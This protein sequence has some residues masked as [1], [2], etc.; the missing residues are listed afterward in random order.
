[1]AIKFFRRYFATGSIG[2]IHRGGADY[3]TKTYGYDSFGNKNSVTATG[4]GMSS[5]ISTITYDSL[6]RFPITSVDSLGNAEH[7][8][9]SA[10][11]G[12]LH[13]FQ[14]ANLLTTTWG[15]DALGRK[16]SE[17][18]PDGTS[19]NVTYS[20]LCTTSCGQQTY[21]VQIATSGEPTVTTYYDLLDREYQ[22]SMGGFNSSTIWS[23]KSYDGVGR[24]LATSRN[25]YS[26]GAPSYTYF[27]Y[28]NG[29][30]IVQKYDPDGGFQKWSY[31]NLTTTISND[32]NQ[33]RIETKDSLG[34]LSQA[35]DAAGQV[36]QYKY[37]PFGNLTTTTDPQG[38]Q[39][40]ATY[41]VMGRKTRVKDPD[42]G[43][44]T[45]TY[46]GAGDQL[47]QTDAKNQTQTMTYDLFG[48]L[49]TKQ[50]IEF[51]GTWTYDTATNGLE[52][53]ASVTNSAGFTK[54]FTYD[55]YGRVANEQTTTDT[56]YTIG[57]SYDSNSRLSQITY[58]T[59]FAVSYQYDSNGYLKELDNAS[60]SAM[61]WQRNAQNADN[62]SLQDTFGNGVVS[63]STYYTTTGRLQSL[64]ATSGSTT[65]QN[66]NVSYDTL[67]NVTQRTDLTNQ[68]TGANLTDSY[69]YDNLNRL[70][71]D[72]NARETANFSYDPLGDM[73]SKTNVG[74]MKYGDGRSGRPLHAVMSTNGPTQNTYSYDA[75][76]NMISGA[77]R[78]VTWTSFNKPATLANASNTI[79]FSYDPSFGRYKE[80]ETTCQDYLGNSSTTCTKYLVNPREDIGIH[81]EK[82]INGS[83]TSY[84][85]SLYAG[86]GN[87]VGVYTTRSDGTSSTNYYHKDHLGSVVLSTTDNAGVVERSSYD[88]FGKRRNVIGTD[89]PSDLLRSKVSHQ[90][91]TGHEMMDDGG[92]GLINMNGRVYEP[93]LGRFMS[94]DPHVQQPGNLQ[95]LN[96]Y[97]YTANNPVSLT[98][99][100]GYLFG[101]NINLG[102]VVG[103]VAGAVTG[104]DI[105]ALAGGIFGSSNPYVQSHAGQIA[106]GEAV[107]AASVLTFGGVDAALGGGL[108]AAVIAGATSG[109]VAGGLSSTLSSGGFSWQDVEMGAVTG[110]IS[111]GAGSL[112]SGA[113]PA[114]QIAVGG[115][116]GGTT[117]WLQSA[118]QGH[119]GIHSFIDG[120]IL[121]TVI[122]ATEVGLGYLGS[123]SEQSA[124]SN[125][126]RSPAMVESAS[127]GGGAGPDDYEGGSGGV[128]LNGG[129]SE[130][131]D[132]DV[133]GNGSFNYSDHAVTRM[134]QND[135]THEDVVD[136]IMN[137]A[138]VPGQNATGFTTTFDGNGL[139][140]VVGADGNTIVTVFPNGQ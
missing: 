8:T 20:T 31:S 137:N 28:D 33:Q 75:N 90:G 1:V 95:S 135:I 99:P 42:L 56:S 89:D 29:N 45:Y 53:L 130:F 6:G 76:G 120:A 123:S 58:P 139:R 48:R 85:H 128:G 16:T 74:D 94:A 37:D 80:V 93:L 23:Y 27:T 18:R 109:A 64:V 77:G 57:R 65:L 61:L 105:G 43:T 36:T 63:A 113:G 34:Q 125:A 59:G 70:T 112:A 2:T 132:A 30:R 87:V 129:G 55:S 115:L 44:W 69:N 134:N 46:D 96:R 47:T 62:L 119:A 103:A 100:S 22:R 10:A 108:G 81:F 32:K 12:S 78:T 7:R 114:V 84:R 17:T 66:L 11:F 82:E 121:G 25:A 126:D 127:G 102:T 54:A 133:S 24:L 40:V 86:S 111:G 107:L 138:G 35:T 71:G 21:N 50:T 101:I 79:T 72:V 98:D 14:D 124:V 4:S 83:I 91:F 97:S 67:G 39:I 92:I 118:A 68:Y 104:G 140:V 131:G 110:A 5:R 26:G 13:T 73:V 122:S 9:Y 49:L 116:S 19:T 3:L 41:D 106:A 60:T 117:N 52:K 15:I 38:H 136:I 51:T 88:A